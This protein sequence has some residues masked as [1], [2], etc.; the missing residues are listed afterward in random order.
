MTEEAKTHQFS[1]SLVYFFIQKKTRS[2]LETVFIE[3]QTN[4]SVLGKSLQS[5][6][7]AADVL[8][9]SV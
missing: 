5:D 3:T 4:I 6:F 8:R 2:L 9:F 1:R 7:A